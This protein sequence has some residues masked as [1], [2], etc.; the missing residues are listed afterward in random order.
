MPLTIS[1]SVIKTWRRCHAK[2]G[3][4]YRQLLERKKPKLQLIRGT[5]IGKCLDAQ[6]LQRVAKKAPA[7]QKAL[8]PYR[9][10]FARMFASER[11]YY[12]DPIAEV[13]RICARYERIYEAD[14]FTYLLGKD[15][16]PF[17]LKLEIDLIPGVVFTGSI[18]KMPRDEHGR[19]WDLDHKSHKR[20]P[21]A[22]ARFSDLQQVFY[23]W[24]APQSGYPKLAGVIWDYLRTKAPAIPEQLKNGGLSQ[25]QNIDTDYDTYLGEIQRL[26]LNPKDY[27]EILGKLKAEGHSQFYLRVPLPT[28][29]KDLIKNVVADAKATAKEIKTNG[30]DMTRSMDFTCKGCEFYS[31]CQAEFRGLDAKYIRKTEYQLQKEVRHDHSQEEDED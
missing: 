7:W 14:G 30:G 26:K 22:E 20:I 23:C 15:K 1:Q 11:E 12:G 21:D 2:Y 16:K 18:D 29:S 6:A 28:P 19:V 8:D 10:Q 3:Y 31:L 9:K 4:K 27:S 5:M 25:R 17:E 13:E 24:A